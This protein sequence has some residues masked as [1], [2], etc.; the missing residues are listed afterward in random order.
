[1]FAGDGII[2]L[3]LPVLNKASLISA[4]HLF[5]PVEI[6]VLQTLTILL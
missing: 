4:G 2:A 5:V 3:F 1:L 6:K